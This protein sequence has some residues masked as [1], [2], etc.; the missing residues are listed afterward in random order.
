MLPMAKHDLKYKGDEMQITRNELCAL[1]D[2]AAVLRFHH[3]G[4]DGGL[5]LL[6]WE[7]IKVTDALDAWLSRETHERDERFRLT[8]KEPEYT[9]LNEDGSR[10]VVEKPDG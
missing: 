10:I 3:D 4:L 9:V 7:L 8:T 2:R 5:D 1:R 6:L